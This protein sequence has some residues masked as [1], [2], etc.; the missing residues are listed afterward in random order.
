[1]RMEKPF[2]QLFKEYFNFSRKDRN[3]VII[4]GVLIGLVFIAHFVVDHIEIKTPNDFSGFEQALEKWEGQNSDIPEFYSLFE[5]NPNTVS[6]EKLDSLSIPSFVKRNL[7]SYRAAGGQFEKP[8][9][10]RKLYG[11][12]D[13]IF[14]LIEPFIAIPEKNAPSVVKKEQADPV[15]ISGTFDPNEANAEELLRFGFDRFQVSNLLKY[16]EKGGDFS[17]PEDLMKI[18]GID[19]AIFALVKPHILIREKPEEIAL[20]EENSSPPLLIEL[21]SADSL[22]LI[23]LKGVGP[24]FASRILKYRELLGGYYSVS[25]LMEVYGFPEETFLSIKEN[26][27]TDTMKVEKIRINFVDFPGLLRHPYLNKVH[28]EAILNY[29]QKNG[30]FISNDQVL[31]AGLIDTATFVNLLPYLTCR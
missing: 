25:Q 14:S 24:V 9:D 6:K 30:P 10:V 20:E 18:Y 2:R 7:L 3:A 21:N 23:C 13:S 16:R 15:I 26:I 17:R 4:L 22:Q 19:S 11:M 8:S 12:N 31:K 29:R 5:F 1:M 28:V 27:F